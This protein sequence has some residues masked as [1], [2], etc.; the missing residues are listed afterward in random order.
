VAI[1]LAVSNMC[2]DIVVGFVSGYTAT[3]VKIF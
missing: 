1:H 3:L 2:Y